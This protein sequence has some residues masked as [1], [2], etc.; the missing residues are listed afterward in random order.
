MKFIKYFLEFLLIYFL[1]IIFKIIGHKNSNI[2]SSKIFKLFGPLSRSKKIIINNIKTAFPNISEDEIKKIISSMWSN[3]GMILSEYVYMKR[4]SR[5]DNNSYVKIEG[6]EYLKE[7]ISSKRQ[8]IFI[9]AHFDNFEL[10]AMHLEKS[11]LKLAAIYRPLNNFFLNPL[12]E[13][14]RKKYICKNQIRKGMPGMRDLINFFRDGYS[15]ALMVDQ[16]VSEG[17]RSEFF[18]KKALTTTIPAQF[19]KK[20][21]CQ[22]I[23]VFIQR[24]SIIDFTIRISKPIHLHKEMTIENITLNINQ[25]IE[26]MIKFKPSQWIWSHNRWK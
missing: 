8:A 13:R 5:N 6:E 12:M 22:I 24:N 14:I 2:L 21:D 1:F 17:I 26:K 3:Y 15:I 25:E 20:Y 18:G 4:I 9:S 7:L 10:M 23:P 11:G 19:Y 16:R